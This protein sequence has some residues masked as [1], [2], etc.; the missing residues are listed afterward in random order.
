MELPLEKEDAGGIAGAC[1][2]TDLEPNRRIVFARNSTDLAL[3]ALKPL[4]IVRR[5]DEVG[6]WACGD[7]GFIVSDTQF[8]FP[9]LFVC[10][11]VTQMWFAYEL[12]KAKRGYSSE[13]VEE[14]VEY[15]CQ[16]GTGV[17]VA[18]RKLDWYSLLPKEVWVSWLA[19][20]VLVNTEQTIF[21]KQEWARELDVL[22]DA[23]RQQGYVQFDPQLPPHMMSRLAEYMTA[24]REFQSGHKI[25]QLD[26]GY[27]VW[28]SEP[29]A[30]HLTHQFTT[31]IR[32]ITDDPSLHAVRP[33][34]LWYPEGSN[35][36]IHIDQYPPF[37]YAMSLCV[38]HTGPPQPLCFVSDRV[39]KRVV[40]I[41]LPVGQVFLFRGQ[42]TP[43][44]RDRLPKG[45]TMTGISMSWN[46]ANPL[47]DRYTNMPSAL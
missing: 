21:R 18:E 40:D 1:V 6:S 12:P 34:S 23:F 17:G 32:Y 41:H 10:H 16:I 15:L 7:A 36:P 5:G 35:I 37:F 27:F 38:C 33:V 24:L 14:A 42:V 3:K 19:N 45:S 31:I 8:S 44:F 13:S 11:P 30:R 39:P 2:A 29:F 43:H 28:W 47:S 22:R 46:T 26:N 25:R 20:G 4:V 9:C